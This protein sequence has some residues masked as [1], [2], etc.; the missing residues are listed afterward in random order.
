[1]EQTVQNPFAGLDFSHTPDDLLLPDLFYNFEITGL[2]VRESG[3]NKTHCSVCGTQKGKKMLVVEH[4]VLEPVDY[5]GAKISEN[6]VIGTEGD[7]CAH[8]TETLAQRVFGSIY[9]KQLLKVVGVPLNEMG[10]LKGKR[11]Q[12][13]TIQKEIQNQDGSKRTVN[14]FAPGAGGMIGA[15]PLGT[16]AVGMATP[17]ART[18]GGVTAKPSNNGPTPVSTVE[19]PRCQKTLAGNEINDHMAECVAA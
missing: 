10:Q 11:C 2:E 14:N 1:M 9:F 12:R 17:D 16:V 5:Q 15:Y 8:R 18:K 4:T 6:F 3:S 7:P 13:A 19:C